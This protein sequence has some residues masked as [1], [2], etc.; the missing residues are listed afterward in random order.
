MSRCSRTGPRDRERT[1]TAGGTEPARSQGQSPKDA[2][3]TPPAAA[4][5]LQVG[6]LN[7]PPVVPAMHAW[8]EHREP[9]PRGQRTQRPRETTRPKS[10]VAARAPDLAQYPDRCRPACAG[11][12]PGPSSAARPLPPALP[13]TSPLAR[14]PASSFVPPASVS[15][16]ELRKGFETILKGGF[17]AK[18]LFSFHSQN[19]MVCA[20][21]DSE[22]KRIATSP[23]WALQRTHCTVTRRTR[24]RPPNR[25]RRPLA[26]PAK[27][28]T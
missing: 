6:A 3:T 23:N 19:V 26:Q 10:H 7:S 28:L 9:L 18:M 15:A 1:E 2:T 27:K 17:L 25:A 11:P 21:G 12:L 14:S 24:P 5:L 13:L 22:K 20:G 8:H 4:R 16:R